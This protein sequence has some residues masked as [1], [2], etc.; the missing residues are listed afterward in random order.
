MRLRG[1]IGRDHAALSQP[2]GLWL[3]HAENAIVLFRNDGWSVGLHEGLQGI[4]MPGYHGHWDF[5]F[6]IDSEVHPDNC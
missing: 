3:H 2:L 4:I 1:T 6:G 5:G